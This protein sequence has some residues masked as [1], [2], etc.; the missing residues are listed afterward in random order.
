MSE[1]EIVPIRRKDS[2]TQRSET[3][4]VG[5]LG[6]GLNRSHVAVNVRHQDF[7]PGG[8]EEGLSI[9]E[10][11]VNQS[12]ADVKFGGNAGDRNLLAVFEAAT[13][14]LSHQ[15]PVIGFGDAGH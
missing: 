10:I 6:K 4:P 12:G 11:E 13:G 2:V 15:Y 3:V 1:V 7:L 5:V 14:N 9:S 8:I